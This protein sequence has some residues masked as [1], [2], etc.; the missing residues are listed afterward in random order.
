MLTLTERNGICH[1]DIKPE[2]IVIKRDSSKVHIRVIDFGLS[3]Y[4][5]ERI[6]TY[7]QSR[8]YRAPEI[9]LGIP[10]SP[11]IDVWSLGMMLVELATGTPLCAGE[12]EIEQ[13]MML[14]E[15]FGAPAPELVQ[16]GKRKS[17]FFDSHNRPR[18][19]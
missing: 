8:I 12:N 7:I 16:Q 2:N 15:V 18:S 14:M 4:E 6:Y 19:I 9:M 1:C 11:K 5:H 17:K 10:Y 3:C 13:M